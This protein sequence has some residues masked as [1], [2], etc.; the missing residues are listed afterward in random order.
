MNCPIYGLHNPFLKPERYNLYGDVAFKAAA[1]LRDP[2]ILDFFAK[3]I[4]RVSPKSY[5]QAKGEVIVTRRFLENLSGDG[6]RFITK[7]F[8][9]AGDCA[10]QQSQAYRW[11][12]G[13]VMHIAPFNFPFEIPVL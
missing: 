4:Q 9:V 11:P 3:S 6:P 8:T 5:Q 12:Y 13:P 7:G 10:G 1:A 2:E